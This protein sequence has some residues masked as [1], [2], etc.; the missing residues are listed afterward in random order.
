[1]RADRYMYVRSSGGAHFP[2]R[3]N[4]DG[5]APPFTRKYIKKHLKKNPWIAL[6]VPMPANSFA[7]MCKK[8]W[9]LIANGVI[10]QDSDKSRIDS[11]I[12]RFPPNRSARKPHTTDVRGCAMT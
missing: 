6:T 12:T 1:M 11:P 8:K 10:R 7:Q 5:S 3:A 4:M 9:N 2:N